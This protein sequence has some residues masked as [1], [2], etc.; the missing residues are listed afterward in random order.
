MAL[1]YANVFLPTYT[2]AAANLI[3]QRM[4]QRDRFQFE[5][6]DIHKSWPGKCRTHWTFGGHELF[7][8]IRPGVLWYPSGASRFAI[9][10]GIVDGT[11]LAAI[12]QQALSGQT[13]SARTFIMS[14]QD[15]QGNTVSSITLQMYMLPPRPLFQNPG[16]GL[17]ATPRTDLWLITLVDDRY[18]FWLKNTGNIS[19]STGVQWSALYSTLAADLGITLTAD[20]INTNYNNYFV[21]TLF[22]AHYDNAAFMLDGAAYNVGQRIVRALGGSYNA[23]NVATSVAQVKTNLL[24]LNTLAGGGLLNVRCDVTPNTYPSLVGQALDTPGLLP[25]KVTVA[26]P[27]T[28]DGSPTTELW[29]VDVN[30]TDLTL[31]ELSCSATNQG[32]KTFRDTQEAIFTQGVW[33]NQSTLQNLANQIALDWYR[34]QS[35]WVEARFPGIVAWAPEGL[36]DAIEWIYREDELATRVLR[37]PWNDMTEELMHGDATVDSLQPVFDVC[38]KFVNVHDCSNNCIQVLQDIVIQ[39]RTIYWPEAICP[40]QRITTGDNFCQ[41]TPICDCGGGQGT[42]SGSGSGT[43]GIVTQCCPVPTPPTLNCT[44]TVPGCCINGQVVPLAYQGL[45]LGNPWWYGT[46]PGVCGGVP[47]C[48]GGCTLFIAL[49]CVQN[50]I[51]TGWSLN[52]CC[53]PP[54]NCPPPPSLGSVTTRQL[55]IC[56]PFLLQF[57]SNA[58]DVCCGSSSITFTVTK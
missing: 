51:F 30:F 45:S 36:S 53:T 35:A 12:R 11:A 2:G 16:E 26:F 21:S 52:F 24:G 56:N 33:S 6:P 28:E 31:P 46:I 34:Y 40:E 57:K 39:K 15:S 20:A 19:T 42:P 50:P 43:G 13:Y 38:R 44:C 55:A 49:V 8:P 4:S 32:T 18:F 41:I 29:P 22:S 25:K 7:P 54:A 37:P 47:G 1:S 14:Q 27:L 3:L 5:Q 58:G 48:M 9:F 10:Y 23:W 17:S